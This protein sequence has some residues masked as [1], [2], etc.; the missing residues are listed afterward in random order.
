MPPSPTARER[1]R[2]RILEKLAA[3]AR[4]GRDASHAAALNIFYDLCYEFDSLRDFKSICVLIPD[5]CL[6]AP[7]SLY[8]RGPKGDLRL[9]RTTASQ[10]GSSPALPP[11]PC[12]DPGAV[13][14]HAG[15]FAAPICETGPERGVLGLLCLHREPTP[16]GEA[17]LVD[18]A[19]RVSLV[20]AAKQAALG[21]RQR[22]AFIG[23]LMRD[24]GHNVIVPNM[25]FKLLFIEM[26]RQLA[27]LGGKIEAL[28]P[29]RP[30]SPDREVRRELAALVKDLLARQEAISRRFQ[31]S[32]LFL[33]SLLRRGHFEKGRYDLLL[34]PCR[35]KSQIMEPELERFRPLFGAQGI[36]VRVA[37]D[38]RIDEDVVLESDL[39]LM[40]QVFANLLSN[41]VKYTRPMPSPQGNPEKLLQYGWESLPDAFGPGCPGVRLFV[42]TTGPGIAPEERSRLFDPDFRSASSETA[43][44]SGHGLFFVKQIVEL[45][46]GRVGYGR[47][48]HMNTFHITLPGPRQ[49]AGR[50]K[51]EACPRPS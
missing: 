23:N 16:D 11:P 6:G 47:T 14:R 30:D 50:A 35:F 12:P 26:H 2:A 8:L 49:A 7:A 29:A 20:M 10:G 25:H 41:A 39:G 46:G 37:P 32:S 43:E 33:E 4:D 15:F 42:S 17:F 38:V 48:E 13:I 36:A 1:I 40:A 34:R 45:H 21:N 51:D 18:Y 5:A 31:Q 44:G 28:A 22:L 24:I 19:R 27:L 3:S 9:V